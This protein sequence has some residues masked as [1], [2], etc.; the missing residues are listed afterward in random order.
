MSFQS[1][2][3]QNSMDYKIVNKP[4]NYISFTSTNLE[5]H[6]FIYHVYVSLFAVQTSN[7]WGSDSAGPAQ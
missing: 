5:H 3:S 4:F 2:V 1:K 6:H 7:P